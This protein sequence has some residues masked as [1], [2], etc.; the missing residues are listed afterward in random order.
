MMNLKLVYRA[1]LRY[2]F[3]NVRSSSGVKEEGG[4]KRREEM[5]EIREEAFIF[6]FQSLIILHKDSRTWL[7]Y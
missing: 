6:S 4:R 5:R 2:L 3:C 1:R 7:Y